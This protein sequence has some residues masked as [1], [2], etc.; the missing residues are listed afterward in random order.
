M[1][2]RHQTA[3]FARRFDESPHGPPFIFWVKTMDES[4]LFANESIQNKYLDDWVISR[5]YG[6]C[7]PAFRERVRHVV[8]V[9]DEDHRVDAIA[10]LTRA[11]ECGKLPKYVR[12]LEVHQRENFAQ[13]YPKDLEALKIVRAH[14]FFMTCY[15]ELGCTR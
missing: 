15:S 10:V 14:I 11:A 6:S 1:D 7:N 8:S 9:Y 4:D 12:K 5:A 3:L 2:A 13:E